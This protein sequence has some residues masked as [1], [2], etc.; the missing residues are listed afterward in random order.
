MVALFPV[1]LSAQNAEK[2][3]NEFSGLVRG[4]EYYSSNQELSV[5]VI[6]DL[7]ENSFR[8]LDHYTIQPN[9]IFWLK[10]VLENRFAR[11]DEFFIHFYGHLDEVYLYQKSINGE[12][13]VRQ[14]GILVPEKLKSVKG[15]IKDKIPFMI[16]EGTQTVLYLQIK[17]KIVKELDISGIQII[18]SES[19]SRTIS[20]TKQIQSFFFGNC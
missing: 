8:K 16:T 17:N 15:Y 6:E 20:Q 13:T 14:S 3:D 7:P 19:F 18:D 2:S 5:N 11:S 12:W 10:V 1:H 4:I 9:E